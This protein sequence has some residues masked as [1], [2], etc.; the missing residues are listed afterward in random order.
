MKYFSKRVVLTSGGSEAAKTAA[1]QLVCRLWQWLCVG[2]ILRLHCCLPAFLVVGNLDSDSETAQLTSLLHARIQII[3]P[4]F[5]F[6]IPLSCRLV[7]IECTGQSR[8]ILF[9]KTCPS[10][11]TAIFAIKLGN[12][13]N[14]IKIYSTFC[15]KTIFII[16]FVILNFVFRQ[17]KYILLQLFSYF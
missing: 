17:K 2:P 4:V 6:Y 7:F 16:I 1:H 14:N 10:P 8:H 12:N 15:F 11:T 13:N 5:T 9:S 3:S